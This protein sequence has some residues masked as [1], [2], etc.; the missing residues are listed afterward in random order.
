M[1]E[2]SHNKLNESSNANLNY[3]LQVQTAKQ[4]DSKLK[5]PKIR[6]L[7]LNL[8]QKYMENTQSSKQ[9]MGQN[10]LLLNQSPKAADYVMHNMKFA[11]VAN[12]ST[13]IKEVTGENFFTQYGAKFPST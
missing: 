6:S 12:F 10:K 7:T 8:S 9:T 5:L 1:N 4:Q 13:T 2:Q 11:N 3:E